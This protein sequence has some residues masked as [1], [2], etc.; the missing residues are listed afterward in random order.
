VMKINLTGD[1][2]VSHTLE[3][4]FRGGG[5]RHLPGRCCTSYWEAVHKDSSMG[6]CAK[7]F[8]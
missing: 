2:P 7:K 1:L 8:W 3:A 6:N 5:K 4:S